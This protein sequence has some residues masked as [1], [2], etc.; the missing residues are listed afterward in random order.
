MNINFFRIWSCCKI[1]GNEEFTNML[2][3]VLPIH[4]P[5]IPVVKRSFLS[6][7]K[8]VR[9]HVKLTGMKQRTQCNKYS[10]LLH[11]QPPDGVKKVKTFFLR[12]VMLHI[13]LKGKKCRTICKFDLM[14]TSDILVGEKSQTL[15]L[16]RKVY[17]DWSSL[18]LLSEWYP[19]WT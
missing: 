17:F 9:L 5:L 16:C 7:M 10:A 4:I 18:W 6:F 8:V 1:K 19:K 12:N 11:R 14:H 2:A 3:N 13:K 15:K